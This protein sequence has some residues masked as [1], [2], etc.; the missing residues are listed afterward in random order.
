M[1]NEH[2]AVSITGMM[3]DRILGMQERGKYGSI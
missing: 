2:T 1:L 3:Q